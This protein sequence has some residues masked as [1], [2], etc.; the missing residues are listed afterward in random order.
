[1][2]EN[3]DKYMP[4]YYKDEEGEFQELGEKELDDIFGK[5]S[6]PFS[7]L[8]NIMEDVLPKE[9]ILNSSDGGNWKIQTILNTDSRKYEVHVWIYNTVDIP[10]YETINEDEANFSHN[11]YV[12]GFQSHT[13]KKLTNIHT[14][15]IIDIEIKNI[16]EEIDDSD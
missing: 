3:L 5:T 8:K 15:D 13:I 9:I 4:L 2:F 7:V 10:V 11:M 14:G 12:A 1:M 6:S 16:G